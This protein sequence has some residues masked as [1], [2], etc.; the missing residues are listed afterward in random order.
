MVFVLM[1]C[2]R[3]EEIVDLLGKG[4][5]MKFPARLFL[6][7]LIPCLMMS[8]PARALESDTDILVSQAWVRAMPPS[9]ENTA[10]YMTIENR[11][12]GELVL[13]SAATNAART[14]ELHQM[15]HSGD[16]MKMQQVDTLPIPPGGRLMLKPHGYH[17]MLIHLHKP[18]TEGETVPI[19]LHFAGGRSLTVNAVVSKWGQGM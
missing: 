4:D 3:K 9:M 2:W 18:L 7:F 1:D 19:V 17:L 14:V 6:L 16:V 5:F 8:G 12:D 15:M 13:E 10:A 11:T